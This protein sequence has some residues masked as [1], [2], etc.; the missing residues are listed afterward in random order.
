MPLPGMRGTGEPPQPP[1]LSE[2]AKTL[3]EAEIANGFEGKLIFAANAAVVLLVV[4]VIF[5]TLLTAGPDKPPRKQRKEKGGDA[6]AAPKGKDGRYTAAEVAKHSKPV[7]TPHG[8]AP[9]VRAARAAT[10]SAAWPAAG[11]PASQ[12]RVLTP[13]RLAC[14]RDA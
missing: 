11:R 4:T 7:R 2:A 14:A 6:A 13:W 12:R 1:P 5:F 8:R 10:V 9:C 3:R